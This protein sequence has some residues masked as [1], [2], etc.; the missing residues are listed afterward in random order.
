MTYP[1]VGK[2][3]CLFGFFLIIL[4]TYFGFVGSSL[5]RGLFSGFEKWGLL[6]SRGPRA[7][8][9]GG[10]SCCGA[11][12]PGVSWAQEHRLNN[13]AQGLSVLCSMWDLSGSGIKPL[14]PALAGGFSTAEPPGKPHRSLLFVKF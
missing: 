7:S 13:V 10:F 9:C 5:L 12:A 8:D 1:C 6:D 14:S 11:G 2:S 3:F 4:F